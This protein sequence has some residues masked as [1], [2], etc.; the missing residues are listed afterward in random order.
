MAARRPGNDRTAVGYWR[1][2][3]R[4]RRKPASRAVHVAI[5]DMVTANEGASYDSA[6]SA[7][8]LTD[9]ANI[10]ADEIRASQSACLL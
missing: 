6:L 1:D 2:V 8:Y 5:G 4:H 10:L 9:M 3:K 7:A